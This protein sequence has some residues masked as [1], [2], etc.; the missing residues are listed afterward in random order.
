MTATSLRISCSDWRVVAS[1]SRLAF[2]SISACS[3]L[4]FSWPSFS[5][6]SAA[7]RARA[8][9]SSDCERAS[10][11]RWRYSASSSSASLRVR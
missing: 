6:F 7:L 11:R 9:I 3:A 1:M 2:S 10:C 4:A 8:T 5:V